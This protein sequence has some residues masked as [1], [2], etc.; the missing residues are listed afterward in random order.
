VGLAAMGGLAHRL[1][2]E[3]L[4][5]AQATPAGDGGS[6]AGVPWVQAD[7]ARAHARLEAMR[8]LNWR[9]ATATAAGTLGPAESSAVKVYGTECVVDVYRTLL[10]VVGSAGAVKAGS[11]GSVLRGELERAG[12][13]A[14]INTF[15]GGVNEIQREIVAWQALGMTRQAR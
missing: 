3:V 13:Q 15:G 14:Q 1:W 2:E 9:M 12:R 5:W 8:L 4:A 7:L 6:V 11:P 10:G